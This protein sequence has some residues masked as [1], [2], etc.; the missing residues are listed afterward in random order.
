MLIFFVVWRKNVITGRLFYFIEFHASC[1]P[2]IAY[3]LLIKITLKFIHK[4]NYIRGNWMPWAV[5]WIIITCL[6]VS[7]LSFWYVRQILRDFGLGV[8]MDKAS[9]SLKDC[10]A[11]LFFFSVICPITDA[12]DTN[13]SV[14][15]FLWWDESLPAVNIGA[16]WR[17]CLAFI[18]SLHL[19]TLLVLRFRL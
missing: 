4:A 16:W 3:L 11:N 6:R 8:F 5:L 12:H 1:K 7:W 10:S 18:L 13:E 15:N 9:S 17:Y 2:W 14:L 19:I